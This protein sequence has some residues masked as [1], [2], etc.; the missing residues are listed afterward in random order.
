MESITRRRKR[1]ALASAGGLALTAVVIILLNVI[2][3]WV[4]LRFDM[5][6]SRAYS[7]SPSTKK[8]VSHL[9][10]PVIVKAF[11]TP[12]LPA[13]FNTNERYIRDMLTEYR[14]A[15]HGRVRFEFAL[16]NPQKD[17][18][19]HAVE[20]GMAPLQFNQMG[21]DQF[22][23]RRG[24]MGLVMYYRDKSETIPVIKSVQNF[25]YD[26]TSRIAKM[27]HSTKKVIGL[28]TGHGETEWR[29]P[30]FKLSQDL[31]ELYTFLP[32]PLP[33]A[34]PMPA[35]MDALLVVGPKQKM[36][37]RSLW[38]IDQAIMRGTPVAFL[39]DAKNVMVQQF[40]AAPVDSGLSPLLEQYGMK[41]GN[42][43]VCDAQCETVTMTQNVFGLSIPTSVRYFLIPLVT[44]FKEDQPVTQGLE[45]LGLP[46]PV[47]LTPTGGAGVV[48]LS[49]IFYSSS[50]SWLL[51]VAQ[52]RV[53]P[54]S[55]PNPKPGEP[56]GPFLLGAMLE[57]NFTSYFN[58]KPLPKGAAGPLIG[59]SPKTKIFVLGTSH[60]LDPSMP[61]FPGA[62]AVMSNLIA[63]LANDETLIGIHSKGEILKPLK[64]VSVPARQAARFFAVLGV[65]ILAIGWGI[66]RWRRRQLWRQLIAA[67]YAPKSSAPAV[68]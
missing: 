65:P 36:D 28:T 34:A 33:P 19:Q 51:P 43:L 66:W 15:S 10:D 29:T 2:S 22:Q 11:F 55:I 53:S 37:D 48:K 54:D 20:A 8:L 4:Y 57:G 35:T 52:P 63:Y 13:P 60:L 58:G 27:S 23:V 16:T 44:L 45:S 50:R 64:P 18:E 21:S 7:L 9:D 30:E 26:V 6:G 39:V 1:F 61:T 62:D 14:A 47:S 41:L 3:G 42:Q 68:P 56:T 17:F 46:F 59:S 32:V 31:A 12:D 5:T 38:E 40:Y 25:E 67:A 24:F 49:P